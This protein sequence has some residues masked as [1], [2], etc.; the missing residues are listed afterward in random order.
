VL[1]AFRHRQP[2]RQ[3]PA[4]HADALVSAYLEVCEW[5]GGDGTA[6]RQLAATSI[7]A[8][9]VQSLDP[10]G[11]HRDAHHGLAWRRGRGAPCRLPIAR[12]ADAVRG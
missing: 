12:D 8:W 9:A 10:A 5:L 1:A 2:R 7:G 11:W 6:A 3:A 4:A